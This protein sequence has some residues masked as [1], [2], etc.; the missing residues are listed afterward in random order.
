[1]QQISSIRSS[2]Q[3][4]SEG[5]MDPFSQFGGAARG[6]T[7]VFSISVFCL[8]ISIA[9]FNDASRISPNALGGG[10][11]KLQIRYSKLSGTCF[12]F[13][14]FHTKRIFTSTM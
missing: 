9:A 6:Q 10:T 2:F 13:P 7:C 11:E 8:I 12:F 4:A 1:M 5:E 3:I 14:I